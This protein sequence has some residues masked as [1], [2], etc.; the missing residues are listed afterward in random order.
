M[1]SPRVCDR[2]KKEL[3]IPDF[4]APASGIRYSCKKR[5]LTYSRNYQKAHPELR[6]RYDKEYARKNSKRRWALAC[7]AGHRRRGFTIEMTSEELFQM[8]SKTDVCFICG[9][10][11]DWQLGN[12]GKMNRCSPTLDRLDNESVIRRNSVAILCCRCN[13]TKRERTMREFLEYCNSVV[14]RFHSHFEYPQLLHR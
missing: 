10:R 9:C 8:A 6:R 3:P 1:P 13:A 11:L 4:Y 5:E 2:C 12:N 14:V 7:L